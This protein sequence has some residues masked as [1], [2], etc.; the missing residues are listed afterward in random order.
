MAI[1]G[2]V[3]LRLDGEE[4]KRIDLLVQRR[5][6]KSRNDAIRKML[7]SRLSEELT[8]DEDVHDL[9]AMMLK[10][11]QKGKNPVVLRPRKSAVTTVTEGRN[12]W[13]T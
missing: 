8:E 11:K 2:I 3:T 12:R 5:V 13:H 1:M 10:L 9:V 6:Y 4:L 7:S